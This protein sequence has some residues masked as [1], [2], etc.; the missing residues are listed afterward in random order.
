MFLDSNANLGSKAYL[1]SNYLWSTEFYALHAKIQRPFIKKIVDVRGDEN[2]E[3]M[4][5][6]KRVML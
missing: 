6:T 3:S 4:G 2:C 1:G 5:L